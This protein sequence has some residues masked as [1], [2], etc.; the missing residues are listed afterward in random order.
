MSLSPNDAMLASCS[1]DK[2]I[3][4]WNT[5]NLTPI[6]TLNGHK[7]GV[8]RVQFSPV[9]KVRWETGLLRVFECY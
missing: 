1:Q 4:L 2:S 3:R 6:A 7:R 9:D 5:S 8:W